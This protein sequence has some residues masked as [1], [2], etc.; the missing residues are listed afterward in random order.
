MT[1]PLPLSAGQHCV[2]VASRLCQ[3]GFAERFYVAFDNEIRFTHR[4]GRMSYYTDAQ[5]RNLLTNLEADA[6]PTECMNTDEYLA[7]VA[8][9]EA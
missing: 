4:D 7:A 3:L 2:E 9:G 1:T 8:R 6:D 5:C